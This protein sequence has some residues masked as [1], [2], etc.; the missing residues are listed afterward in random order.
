MSG[1]KKSK[2]GEI[3][4]TNE[5]YSVEIT[6]QITSTDMTVK[7]RDSGEVVSNLTYSQIETGAVRKPIN[8]SDYLGINVNMLTSISYS[9][10][11]NNKYNNYPT[12]ILCS[13]ECG[14]S[15][16]I[17]FNDFINKKVISCGCIMKPK[18][19]VGE[20]HNRLL[21]TDLLPSKKYGKHFYKFVKVLC[22]CG[23]TSEVSYKA[24]K[25]GKSK[26]C[27]CL[28]TEQKY[29]MEENQTFTHWT[30]L[31]EMGGYYSSNGEKSDRTFLCRCICG[32]EKEVNLQSLKKGHSK[33]CGCQGIPRKEIAIKEKVIPQGTE[34]EQWKECA[35]FK[36]YYISTL[37]K[38]F[39]FKAQKILD[40][41]N[42]NTIHIGG[43]Q[44][45][46]IKEV[47]RTFIGEYDELIYLP[48]YF[49]E[50]KTVD[51]IRLRETNTERVH[52]LASVYG[53]MKVRCNN[54]NCKSY[55]MYGGKGIKVDESFSTFHK[56]ID[57]AIEQGYEP[58][59]GLEIDRED[60]SKGYSVEN[61]RWVTK[62]ENGLNVRY[63]SLT[64]EDVRWIR[65]DDFTYEKSEE[66]FIASRATIEN[67]REGRT[68][69][70][71]PPI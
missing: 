14:N 3:H 2:V 64:L 54:S 63:I 5:G 51:N 29:V 58:N 42:K 23:N 10:Y 4:V 34:E 57:W 53:N 48:Y 33:S 35:S 19:V 66:K 56:F 49:N 61:C 70:E 11:T 27:G 32:K 22:D 40:Q 21:I 69:I 1:F 6:E 41:K 16:T 68:F 7:F 46:I 15:K 60:S 50:V 25:S 20:K 9:S 28:N 55:S 67:I 43:K 26:S 62:L 30:V 39:A 24:L 36:D 31:K 65:S 47:Y 44:T 37:G 8:E 45:T 12:S 59:K 18:N 38:V 52:K 13:C 71:V 17:R